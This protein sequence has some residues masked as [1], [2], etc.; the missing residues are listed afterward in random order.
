[1]K[2]IC[3]DSICYYG[4][5]IRECS[6][7]EEKKMKLTTAALR[8]PVYYPKF[9][10]TPEGAS[11]ILEDERGRRTILVTLKSDGKGFRPLQPS[12]SPV[13]KNRKGQW[14]VTN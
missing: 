9:L 11:L 13:K 1:M 6:Q 3:R 5:I 2:G 7:P 8:E 10:E 4:C 14:M 12:W